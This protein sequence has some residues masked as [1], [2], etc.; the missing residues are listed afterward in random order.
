MSP[1]VLACVFSAAILHASWNAVLRSGSDRLWSMTLM[2]I[3]VFVASLGAIFFLPFPAKASWLCIVASAAIHAG[4]NI[5]LIRTYDAGDL[6]QTYPVSRGSS[7]VFVA[8]GAAIFARESL[9]ATAVI[10]ILLVSAGIISLAYQNRKLQSALLPA[11]LT[12]GALIGAYTVVDGI[13][14]RLS[15]DSFAYSAWMFLLWS[16]TMPPLYLLLRS[17]PA[18]YSWAEAITAMIGGWVS[19]L[20]YGI[21][22]WAVQFG[23]MG[24]VS[25]LR[26]TSVIFAA[27]IGRV[28]L[29]ERLSLHRLASCAGIAA[30][31]ACLAF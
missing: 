8:L 22:I 11:A 5:S 7:P 10:G 9:T 18:Q 4:Y 15:E 3:A 2:M 23:A 26:E 6:G 21:V 19:I 16:V 25:A 12:T 30:G 1:L 20:A 31:A 13:G 14:V 24:V 28:F 27:I 29:N 17:A